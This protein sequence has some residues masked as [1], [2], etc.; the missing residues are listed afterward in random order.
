MSDF[1]RTQTDL[2][3]LDI[4]TCT[5]TYGVLPC[6]ASG[7]AG[8]ECY[9]TFGTC[10]DQANFD[11]GTKSIKFCSR[12]APIPLSEPG[13]IPSLMSVRAAATEID[14]EKGLSRRRGAD[15][16]LMDSA[17]EDHL[18]DS[19]AATRSQKAIGSFWRRLLARNSNT[20]GRPAR[21]RRA[22]FT[23]GWD[24]A[25]FTDENYIIEAISG[26]DD[27]GQVRIELKDL[28]TLADRRQVPEPK[29]GRLAAALTETGLSATLQTGQGADYAATGYITIGREVIEYTSNSSDVLS[30]PDTGHRGAFGTEAAEHD[31][32]DAVAQARVWTNTP[33]TTVMQNILTESGIDAGDIDTAGFADEEATWLGPSYNV[34]ACIPKPEDSDKLLADLTRIVRGVLWWSPTDNKVRFKVFAP[35]VPG[36]AVPLLTDDAHIIAEST[37]IARQ[38]KLRTTVRATFY[39]LR[40]ATENRSESANY[41]LTAIYIDT[42]AESPNEYGDR[43]NFE[44]FNRWWTADNRV[45]AVSEVTRSALYY[46][47]APV[48]IDLAVS[49]KDASLQEAD[50]VDIETGLYTDTEGRPLRLRS[51]IIRRDQRGDQIRLKCRGTNFAERVAFIAPDTAGDYP[52]DPEYAHI[53]ADANGFSDGTK[54]YVIF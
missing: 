34:T 19:Y 21:L 12:G 3:E 37:K 31:I 39:G 13:I 46:R 36:P 53:A 29:D 18:L 45:A 23:N 7:A 51:I 28:I 6:T 8:S 16:T 40:S 24:N 14:L 1:A 9:N 17:E 22:F 52:S 43:R 15:I 32:D 38:D 5:L 10:Q 33:I 54:P 49:A 30:W 50:I 35:P 25:E 41:N 27:N 26:P 47:D 42:V 48:E 20:S 4:D 2:L 44:S 11:M